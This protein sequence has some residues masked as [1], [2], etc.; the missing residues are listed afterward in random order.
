MKK[1]IKVWLVGWALFW[2]SFVATFFIDYLGIIE[3]NNLGFVE[4][5]W[6]SWILWTVCLGF[7]LAILIRFIEKE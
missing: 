6:I 3:V 4:E 2:L 7:I 1:S 5:I